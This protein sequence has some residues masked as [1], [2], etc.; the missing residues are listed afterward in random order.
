V[1]AAVH[2][3][4]AGLSTD[5]EY[6]VPQEI[7]AS[8][9]GRRRQDRARVRLVKALIA[10]G[11]TAAAA[12]VA[13]QVVSPAARATAFAAAA[14]AADE[15]AAALH[16][17]RQAESAAAVLDGDREASLT[18]AARIAAA[19]E[20]ICAAH[21]EIAQDLAGQL[22]RTAVRLLASEAWG[23]VI[24]LV[25]RLDAAAVQLAATWMTTRLNLQEISSGGP[26]IRR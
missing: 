10:T 8:I 1:A 14:Q 23:E 12:V 18:A 4:A 26:T 11:S 25:G 3:R 5:D 19:T 17:L 15:P 13:E 16:L 7:V 21:P 6:P 9:D 24:P 20:R 2:L 22:P